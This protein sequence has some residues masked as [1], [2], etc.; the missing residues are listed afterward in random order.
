MFQE[1]FP[2]L[3]TRLEESLPKTY[4]NQV[5]MGLHLATL[6]GAL[7]GLTKYVSD[8]DVIYKPACELAS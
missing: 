6:G 3:F 8:L 1:G 7:I 2:E 4:L 5:Q